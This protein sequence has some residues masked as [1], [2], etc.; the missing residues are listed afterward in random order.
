MPTKKGGVE[1]Y[2]SVSNI[3]IAAFLDTQHGIN[4]DKNLIVGKEGVDGKLG[5]SLPLKNI[6]THTVCVVGTLPIELIVVV[7]ESV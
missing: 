3:D 2:G 4:I 7:G 1:I 6:G 5:T